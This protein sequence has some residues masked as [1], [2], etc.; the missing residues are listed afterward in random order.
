MIHSVHFLLKFLCC[1][2]IESASHHE[3]KV[4]KQP[5]IYFDKS[6]PSYLKELLVKKGCCFVS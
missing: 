3:Q 5:S 4:W 1:N 6:N 2:D